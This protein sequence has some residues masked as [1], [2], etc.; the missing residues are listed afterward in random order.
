MLAGE[1]SDQGGIGAPRALRLGGRD[2][3]LSRDGA[4]AA[5]SAVWLDQLGS[6]YMESSLRWRASLLRKKLLPEYL[7]GQPGWLKEGTRSGAEADNGKSEPSQARVQQSGTAA[8]GAGQVAQRGRANLVCVRSTQERTLAIQVTLVS[9]EQN[10]LWEKHAL[11]V[12]HGQM[13]EKD[14]RI[15]LSIGYTTDTLCIRLVGRPGSQ[16]VRAA[17]RWS[18]DPQRQEN[19][20]LAGQPQHSRLHGLHALLGGLVWAAAGAI[21]FGAPRVPWSSTRHL[22]SLWGS[23]KSELA[24]WQPG[25]TLRAADEVVGALQLPR[26]PA[27]ATQRGFPTPAH[28]AVEA[29]CYA[30]YQ[31]QDPPVSFLPALCPVPTYTRLNMV[32]M[33]RSLPCEHRHIIA[34]ICHSKSILRLPAVTEYLGAI[35]PAPKRTNSDSSACNAYSTHGF[36]TLS[37]AGPPAS[38]AECHRDLLS[39]GWFRV[40]I[41]LPPTYLPPHTHPHARAH[42]NARTHTINT[43]NTINEEGRLRRKTTLFQELGMDES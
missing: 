43:I 4:V 35:H 25:P 15:S 11:S 38:D 16:I 5:S 37:Q 17:Y 30:M 32:A 34:V 8:A 28:I 39:R 7:N 6:R 13:N 14:V 40:T 1:R 36:I 23:M 29:G 31:P 19:A 26:F 21:R 10:L 41:P 9:E 12:P 24:R 42:T 33:C 27:A 3:P 2:G 22:A 20:K 18:R